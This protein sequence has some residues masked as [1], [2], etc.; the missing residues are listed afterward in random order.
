MKVL[1]FIMT[2]DREHDLKRVVS[3]LNKNGLDPIIYDDGSTYETKLPNY[4][5]HEHRGKKGFIHTWEDMLKVCRNNNADLYIF[6]GDDFHDLDLERLYKYHQQFKLYPY[7][8]NII[9]DGRTKCWTNLS[10]LDMGDYYRLGFVD[11]GFFCNREALDR[12][13]FSLGSLPN[14][15]HNKANRSSGVGMLL[16]KGFYS[17]RV[18]MYTPKKSLAFHG[19]H[20]SKMHPEE[21][22]KNPL[23]SK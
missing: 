3:H 6:M 9:N 10:C 12:I 22:K 2:Y 18:K 17:T 19:D 1:S 20:E 21:R 11:G 4:H 14:G 23:I 13:N 5:R 8:C 7:A 16:S 15:W